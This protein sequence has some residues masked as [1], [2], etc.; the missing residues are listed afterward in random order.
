MVSLPNF[1]PMPSWVLRELN[2][3]VFNFFWSG[4]RDLVARNIVSQ[5]SDLGGFSMVSIQLKVYSLLSQWVK[6]FLV[7]PNGWTFLLK[8][9]LLDRFDATPFEVFASPI[10]FPA[11]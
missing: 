8:Y 7:S 3:L 6:R 10:D 2:L 11:V 1:I 4:K 9:W 5:S